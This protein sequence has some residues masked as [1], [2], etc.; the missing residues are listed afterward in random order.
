MIK[1]KRYMESKASLNFALRQS[2]QSLMAGPF[3]LCLGVLVWFGITRY[4]VPLPR[5]LLIGV[6]VIYICT[7]VMEIITLLKLKRILDQEYGSKR[8]GRTGE[9]KK[10]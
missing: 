5:W 8:A 6:V 7:F 2:K 3:V 9:D 1:P 10:H 4:I